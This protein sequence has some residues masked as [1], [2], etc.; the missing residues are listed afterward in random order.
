MQNGFKI[1]FFA[2]YDVFYKIINENVKKKIFI[3]KKNSLHS[4]L[5][6]DEDDDLIINARRAFVHSP[7]LINYWSS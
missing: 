5:C 2:I 3:N 7:V 1:S 4:I 6:H